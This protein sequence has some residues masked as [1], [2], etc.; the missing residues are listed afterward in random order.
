MT[1]T[2]LL[3]IL[4]YTPKNIPQGPLTKFPQAMP[5]DCKV[6]D[7]VEAYRNYYLY[8]KKRIAR[9]TKRNIP[10]WFLEKELAK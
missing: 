6:E 5:D 1:E 3:D 9:W 4:K 7:S 2:K 10:D 8:H